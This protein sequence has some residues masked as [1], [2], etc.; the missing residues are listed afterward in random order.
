M[1]VGG[2]GG[3]CHA[4]LAAP[5]AR[6]QRRRRTRNQQSLALVLILIAQRRRN[7]GWGN[8]VV[9]L[10]IVTLFYFIRFLKILFFEF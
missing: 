3:Q 6:A 5:F 2:G 8:V 10:E 4:G 1:L 9:W 7:V